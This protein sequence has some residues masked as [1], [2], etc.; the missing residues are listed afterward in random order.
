MIKPKETEKEIIDNHINNLELIPMTNLIH[1]LHDDHYNNNNDN[2]NNID[3]NNQIIPQPLIE[4]VKEQHIQIKHNNKKAK[5]VE[6][7]A[8]LAGCCY[9]CLFIFIVLLLL[10]SLLFRRGIC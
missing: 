8:I 1:N 2:N 9:F 7:A 4:E 6:E 10:L 5:T 3:I